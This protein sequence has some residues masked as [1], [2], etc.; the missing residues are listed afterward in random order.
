MS[1]SR[2]SDTFQPGDLLNNTYRIESLLGRGGTSEVYRARSEISGRL[3]AL[4]VLKSEFSADKSYLVLMTREEQMRDI[5]HDAV[6]RYSENHR[7]PDGHVY[8]IMD[9]IEGPGLDEK[10][11]QGGM[12]ADD[13]LTV[14]ARVSEGLHAAHSRNVVHRDLSPDN[15]I[16]RGGDPAQAVIID[17]GIAKDENPGAETIVG[18]EF[19]GK[20]AYAAPEQLSGKSDARSDIYS[21]GALILA[22]YRGKVPDVGRNPMEVIRAK[23]LPPDTEG[24]PEP[25]RTLIERMTQPDPDARL[26]TALAVLEAIDPS[27]IAPTTARRPLTEQPKPATAKPAAPAAGKSATPAPAAGKS[28]APLI[29]GIAAALVVAAGIGGWQFGLFGGA[30]KAPQPAATAS[31]ATA[32]STGAEPAAEPAAPDSGAAA[33]LASPFVLRAA[34]AA[35]G[36]TSLSGNVPSEE[37][38]TALTAA[39]GA[40][41]SGDLSLASGDVPDGFAETLGTVLRALGPLPEWQVQVQDKTLSV[42]GRATSDAERQSVLAVL[43][44]PEMAVWQ[45][46]AKIDLPTLTLPSASVEEV[47]AKHTNC[48]PLVLID[49]PAAGYGPQDQIAVTGTVADSETR[50]ALTEEI[51]ALAKGRPV[52]VDAEVL[53]AKVCTVEAR[54][55]RL[56]S[57]PLSVNFLTG[58]QLVPNPSGRYYVNENPVIDVTLPASV[59]DGYIWVSV[60][61]VSGNVYHLLPNLGRPEASVVGL[62]KGLPGDLSLRVAYSLSEAKANGQIAFTVDDSTLGKTKILLLYSK[63]PVFDE[64]RPTTESVEGF[65]ESLAQRAGEGKLSGLSLNSRIL[66]T[67]KR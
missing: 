17:F 59:E 55:P 49:P 4:K 38:R 42:T 8:L 10:L 26:Q 28:A 9:Y 6:V 64:L 30:P 27:W 54:L 21:L 2:S 57:G 22:T 43:Q 19:A 32:A 23:N 11:R 50:V 66:V 3:V 62:R 7:T 25:L 53:N 14:T 65:A 45:A 67:E 20:Y 12:S 60:I 56:P 29:G 16:L 18:N 47:L 31:T 44:T 48:G 41:V 39:M 35:D 46:S 1:Q 33:P 37:A 40:G 61:D 15:I 52:V 51:T 24:V 58:D 5:R 63:A 34:K 36:T 13:L